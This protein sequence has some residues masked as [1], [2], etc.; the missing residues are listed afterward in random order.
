MHYTFACYAHVHERCRNFRIVWAIQ[1]INKTQHN[2]EW[3]IDSPHK[4]SQNTNFHYNSLIL[5]NVVG[6][7]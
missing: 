1:I 6:V 5:Q 2:S 4:L 3:G 7:R